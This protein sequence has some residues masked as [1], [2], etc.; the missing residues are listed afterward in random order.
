MA[1]V[2]KRIAAKVDQLGRYCLSYALNKDAHLK[3]ITDKDPDCLEVIRHSTAHLL[4]QAVKIL[5]PQRKVAI[6]P[7]IEDGF[8]YDFDCD[9]HFST[10][11]LDIIEKKMHELT[12]ADLKVER[13]VMSRDQALQLFAQMGEA[14]QSRNYQ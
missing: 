11:D 5:F 4:A 1:W 6:G 13:R 14:L 9:H 12:K 8:Y 2:A 7:V 3:I 10:E